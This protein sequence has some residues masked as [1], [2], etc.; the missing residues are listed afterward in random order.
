MLRCRLT[1]WLVCAM[2]VLGTHAWAQALSA[3]E[4]ETVGG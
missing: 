2:T 4:G 3:N 1:R